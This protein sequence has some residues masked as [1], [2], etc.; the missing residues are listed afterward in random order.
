MKFRHTV[1]SRVVGVLIPD[2]NWDG[3]SIP[4]PRCFTPRKMLHYPS[5]R[6]L[7][8]RVYLK[9]IKKHCSRQCQN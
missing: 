1:G 7:K 3:W 8:N 4:L 5:Y 2:L 6:R 9:E